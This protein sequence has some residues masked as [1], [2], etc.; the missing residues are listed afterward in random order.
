MA[1][2]QFFKHAHFRRFAIGI[3]AT[4]MWLAVGS[5]YADHGGGHWH[6][7]VTIS[8]SPAQS[9]TAGQYSVP[10]DLTWLGLD[11]ALNPAYGWDALA[12]PASAFLQ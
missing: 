9:V 3:A 2:S 8:G 6:H 5:A 10:S 11:M 7:Q 1:R 12:A 4:T